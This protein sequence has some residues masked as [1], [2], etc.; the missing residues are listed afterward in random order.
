ALAD[1]GSIDE[2]TLSFRAAIGLKPDLPDAHYNLGLIY[3]MQSDWANAVAE[4]QAASKLR[5]GDATVHAR[6]GSAWSKAGDLDRG[7]EQL[8]TALRLD[9]GSA[10]N[11]DT[12]ARMFLKTAAPRAAPHDLRGP[13]TRQRPREQT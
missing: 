6:L 1:E 9:P 7:I 5:F 12:L 2:A 11:H 13:A 8:R 10:G 4:L 3:S